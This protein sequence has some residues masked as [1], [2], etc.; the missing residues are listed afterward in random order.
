MPRSK[1]ISD[2][3]KNRLYKCYNEGR[4]Y[5]I[6]AADLDIKPQSAASIV[7]TMQKRNGVASLPLG[8]AY[9]I[10]MDDEMHHEL[11]DIIGEYPTMS[12]KNI[13]LTLRSRL[14]YKP[15]VTDNCVAKSSDGMLYSLKKIST[16]TINVFKLNYK[17]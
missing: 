4:D 16:I 3:D 2:T 8:G 9:N 13:N 1:R 14:P 7:R 12:L 15:Q 6:L 10:K 17:L 5:L 11:E